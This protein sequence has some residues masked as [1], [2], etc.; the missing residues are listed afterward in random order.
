MMEFFGYLRQDGLAGTRNHV[1]IISN[2]VCTSDAANRIA[3][4]VNGCV[5]FTHRENCALIS[6]D[7]EI[8]FRTLVNLGKNPNLAAVLV[9]SA[10][11]TDPC[12]EPSLSPMRSPKRKNRSICSIHQAGG[13]M[14]ALSQD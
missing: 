8:V 13:V 10:G 14:T 12:L 6:P 11:C 9:V 5:A 2:G 4:E 7:K 3:R 1:G